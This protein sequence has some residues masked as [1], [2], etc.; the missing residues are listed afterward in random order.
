MGGS[1]SRITGSAMED[2]AAAYL[3]S[4]GYEVIERN[5]RAR[6]GEIDIVAKDN[7]TLVFVEVRY[8]K[9]SSMVSPEESLTREKARRLRLAA[10]R[11]L[12]E[13]EIS[14]GVPVRFDLCAVSDG[15]RSFQVLR[16]I[17]GFGQALA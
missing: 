4:T 11:Y 7:G 10:R 5:Y 6:V 13:R 15:G 1:D 17:I 12:A 8:R 3:R 14:D 9:P 2:A 16:N